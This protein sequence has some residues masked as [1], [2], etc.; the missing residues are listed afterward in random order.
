VRHGEGH[1]P[2]RHDAQRPDDDTQG[3]V[4]FVASELHV[5]DVDDGHDEREHRRRDE[6]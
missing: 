4:A 2:D 5:G 3:A 6:R 1:G